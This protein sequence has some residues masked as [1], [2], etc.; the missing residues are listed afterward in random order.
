MSISFHYCMEYS[1][2]ICTFLGFECKPLIGLNSSL[3]KKMPGTK[4]L[5]ALKRQ[6]T[7]KLGFFSYSLSLREE[8]SSGL[9][10]SSSSAEPRLLLSS[11]AISSCRAWICWASLASVSPRVLSCCLSSSSSFCSCFCSSS[12]RKFFCFTN[13]SWILNLCASTFP[14]GVNGKKGGF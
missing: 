4:F 6:R 8:L 12:A 1:F 7:Q 13:S 5:C 14:F 3:F 2:L 11:S 10:C 9:T